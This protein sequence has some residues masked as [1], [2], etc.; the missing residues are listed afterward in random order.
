RAIHSPRAQGRYGS[1]RSADTEGMDGSLHARCSKSGSKTIQGTESAEPE[2]AQ[3]PT[4]G[5]QCGYAFL[6]WSPS[7]AVGGTGCA[8][9][10]GAAFPADEACRRPT[11]VGFHVRIQGPEES[12]GNDV[13]HSCGPLSRSWQ[14][15]GLPKS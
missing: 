8:A 14:R 2:E 4:P 3:Q 1:L 6:H 15:D 9:Q 5:V 10:S 7:G 11:G 13:K 12:S